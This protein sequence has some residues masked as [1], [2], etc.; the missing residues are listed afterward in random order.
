LNR[1]SIDLDDSISVLR[2]EIPDITR[3][4]KSEERDEQEELL[5]E[6]P[7][8]DELFYGS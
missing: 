5:E 1:G 4:K 2:E 7:N 6:E 3:K 8:Y